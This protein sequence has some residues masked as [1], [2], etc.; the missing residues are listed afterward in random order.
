MRHFYNHLRRVKLK[1]KVGKQEKKGYKLFMDQFQNSC[2]IFNLTI[3]SSGQEPPLTLHQ[4]H[5]FK[6]ELDKLL[7]VMVV[8]S[9]RLDSRK[10]F[11]I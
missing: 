5:L 11:P 2:L 3:S 1:E 6:M 4:Q 7:K 10:S 8:Y 9:P